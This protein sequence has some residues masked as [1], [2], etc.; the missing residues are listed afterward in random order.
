MI[1]VDDMWLKSSEFLGS[2]SAFTFKIVIQLGSVFAAAWVFRER[3]LEILHIGKHKH[4]EGENDQQR[5][6]KPRRLNLLHV[7][8]GMVP[9]GILGLLFDDFIEEHLFS[10]PT[11][12]IGLFV[13]AIYM[14]IAD[15]YSVKVKNPQTVDQINYFQAFVIGIS[16]AVAMWPGFSRSGSTIS[17]GVLMKLNHK[18]ASD[19]TFIMAVPIMLAASGLSLLKHYQDIQIAD[20][21]FYILG[22]LA[23][24][25][26]GLIAIKTF[27]HLINKIKLIPFAIY[28]I[29]LV[30]F[31]AILYFGF[32][33]GKG[34]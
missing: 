21:P 33:I 18:A 28:R 16:Q 15:K 13:G 12:M 9:A 7:L 25:T 32:G 24:F 11:V 2:Q 1:L 31:I 34:I 23:A 3:F 14:I 4:V 20:I 10:V 17:T 19:F 30:I 8:V 22:F 29:V 6:S 27:L 5:R 26:V